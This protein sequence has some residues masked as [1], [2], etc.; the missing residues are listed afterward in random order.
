MDRKPWQSSG[1]HRTSFNSDREDFGD[2]RFR[3][4][5]D[6]RSDR[7]ESFGRPDRSDRT[8]RFERSDRSDR[9]NRF[10]RSDRFERSDRFDRFDRAERGDRGDRGDRFGRGDRNER[11]S[12]R[13]GGRSGSRFGDNRGGERRDSRERFSVRSGPRARA[14]QLRQFDATAEFMQHGIVRLDPDL[15][16]AFKS[17]D[18]VNKTLRQL[19]TWMRQMSEQTAVE[20]NEAAPEV[21]EETLEVTTLN[22]GCFEDDDELECDEACECEAEEEVPGADCCCEEEEEGNDACECAASEDKPAASCD[23]VQP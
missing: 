13:F 12:S 20:T 1:S 3:G 22:E 4:D 6:R 2:R 8:D 16:S 15:K 5:S 19:V 23:K 9:P 14:Q 18:D 10:D 7:R 21:V 17:S 11:G